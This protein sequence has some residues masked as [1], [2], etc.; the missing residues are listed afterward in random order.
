MPKERKSA[1][2]TA[3]G[4]KT[5]G[6]SPSTPPVPEDTG[7][8]TASNSQG[9][10]TTTGNNA[11]ML[12]ML[13]S[14]TAGMN[15]LTANLANRATQEPPQTRPI[16]IQ[17]TLQ[18]ENLPNNFQTNN[19]NPIVPQPGTPLVA[20]YASSEL[21]SS[22][23]SQFH[24]IH[25]DVLLSLVL[26]TFLPEHLP[27]LAVR[28]ATGSIKSDYITTLDP[29]TNSLTSHRRTNPIKDIPNVSTLTKLLGIYF[30]IIQSLQP[31]NPGMSR[32]YLLYFRDIVELAEIYEWPSVLQYHLSFHN[33]RLA[34][35]MTSWST[36]E[37]ELKARFLIPKSSASFRQ[38]Q[39]YNPYGNPNTQTKPSHSGQEVCFKWNGEKG[40]SYT[41]CRFTHL[42]NIC[43]GNHP[44]TKC[45]QKSNT[46]KRTNA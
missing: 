37:V 9:T 1:R 15:A 40:C 11:A 22:L 12:A 44:A 45:S 23:K 18:P 7:D 25:H 14:L 46:N 24:D 19:P 33:K 13:T 30:C 34:E 27:K 10:N 21:P 29:E 16:N 2:I 8:A 35:P 42:C 41:P 32:S 26:G 3:R 31:Y 6:P 36:Q 5:T 43:R 17:S 4:K 28:Q 38:S 20:P 39:R